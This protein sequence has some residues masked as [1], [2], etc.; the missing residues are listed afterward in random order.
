MNRIFHIAVFLLLGAVG[1]AC[2]RK[3]LVMENNIVDVTL[4]VEGDLD[5][6]KS[7]FRGLVWDLDAEKVVTTVFVEPGTSKVTIP[8]GHSGFVVHSFGCEATYIA[9]EASF[10]IIAATTN[11][12]DG[13]T[14]ELW[15]T[16]LENSRTLLPSERSLLK[17]ERVRWEPDR[18]W[19][20]TYSGMLPHRGEGERLELEVVARPLFIERV[21]I[22]DDVQGM[23]YLA[24]VE[25]F[26]TGCASGRSL[27]DD[28]LI[29]ECAI[30]VPMY[31]YEGGLIASYVSFGDTYDTTVPRRLMVV[32]TDTGGRK[33][34]STYDLSRSFIGTKVMECLS[35]LAFEQPPIPEGGGLQPTLQDWFDV[36]TPVEI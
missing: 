29:G 30:R 31:R 22:L 10:G 24:S 9:D 11:E 21:V 14:Q 7:L 2:I 3:D 34:L 4:S 23:E 25:A 1:V 5:E 8:A 33:F 18:M 36:L 12:A 15:S 32:A 19:A 6:D 13:I 16:A 26:V 27:V 17:T 20:G 28:K 35:N